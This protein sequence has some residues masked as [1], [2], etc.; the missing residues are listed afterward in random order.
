MQLPKLLYPERVAAATIRGYVTQAHYSV[1]RWLGLA[2][3]E[4]MLGYAV[5]PMTGAQ[6]DTDDFAGSIG[7]VATHLVGPV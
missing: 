6:A 1:L 4:A 7:D 2:S 3:N 5:D